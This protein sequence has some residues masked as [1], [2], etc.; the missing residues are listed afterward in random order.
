MSFFQAVDTIRE[1]TRNTEIV[2]ETLRDRSNV[3]E[4]PIIVKGTLDNYAD[5]LTT[6]HLLES[7]RFPFFVTNELVMTHEIDGPV[8]YELKGSIRTRKPLGAI[9]SSQGRRG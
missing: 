2:V 6:L 3:I 1:R 9:G 5:F 7:L 8:R 4:L